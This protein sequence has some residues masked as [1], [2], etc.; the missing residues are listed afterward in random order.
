MPL[1]LSPYVE[2]AALVK[3]SEEMKTKPEAKIKFYFSN[4]FSNV[5]KSK[6]HRSITQG[7]GAGNTSSHETG[8]TSDD[9]NKTR[10]P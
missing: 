9:S 6:P 2:V 8:N 1:I 4:Y 10:E 7:K 5:E 3:V